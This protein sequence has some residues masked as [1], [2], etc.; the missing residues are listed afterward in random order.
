MGKK[1]QWHSAENAQICM[2]WLTISQD[3]K[4]G[5]NQKGL[6]FWDRVEHDFNDRILALQ[7]RSKKVLKLVGI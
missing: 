5:A 1:K 2:S 3:A 4:E 7:H 6:T